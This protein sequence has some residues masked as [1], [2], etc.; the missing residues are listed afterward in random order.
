MSVF[1]Q[2]GTQFNPAY[3][4][5]QNVVKAARLLI[6]PIQ[7]IATNLQPPHAHA[8]QNRRSGQER[9]KQN[10]AV[11]LD[12]RSPYPRRRQHNSE[13]ETTGDYHK[14]IDVYA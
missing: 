1:K 14:G 6:N 9:R 3:L 4:K 5:P 11:M 10:V 12:T 7:P 2:L 8:S 13:N